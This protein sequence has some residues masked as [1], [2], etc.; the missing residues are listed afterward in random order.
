M[1]LLLVLL[2]ILL[3]LFGTVIVGLG[4]SQ[5]AEYVPILH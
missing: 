2:L 5:I 3:T 4:L 1:V